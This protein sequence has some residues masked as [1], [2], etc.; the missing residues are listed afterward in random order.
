M[1]HLILLGWFKYLLK[2]FASQAGTGASIALKQCDWLCATLG[3]RFSR[4]SDRNLPQ[5]QAFT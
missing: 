3:R 1:L 5:T 4:Q 2:A